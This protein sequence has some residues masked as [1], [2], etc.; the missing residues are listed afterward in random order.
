MPTSHNK[1]DRILDR[2]IYGT[3]GAILAIG[4]AMMALWLSRALW[5][6]A[7]VPGFFYMKFN[8]SLAF[9]G[10]GAGLLAAAHESKRYTLLAGGLVLLI[11]SLTLSE[12]VTGLNFGFDELLL[13]DFHYASSPYPGRMA[14]A[15]SLAFTLAGILL[16][17]PSGRVS[18]TWRTALTELVGFLVFALGAAALVGH[19]E[20]VEYA[21]S[22]GTYA[23]VAPQTAVGFTLLGIGLMALTWRQERIPIAS[24]PLWV[25]ASLCFAVLMIDTAA[26]LGFSTG[27]VYVPLVFCGLWFARPHA[28]FVFA[29]I[30]SLLAILAFLTKS[31]GTVEVHLWV[32]ATNRTIA[33]GAIWVVAVLVYLRQRS[34]MALE[35]STSR[36][37]AIFDHSVDGLIAINEHGIVED[38]NPA[39][40]RIF[41]YEASEVRGRNIKMLMPEP[42]HSEHDGYIARYLA[43]G[44]AKIIGTVGREVS[45]RRKDG[46]VFPMDL[47]ISAF[48][49][50]NE[51]HFS[52]TVRDIT[53]RKA[54]EAA[55]LR[56]TAA[57]E[58]S[59]R[60]L[61]DFAYIASHDLKE[62]LRGL[63]NNATFIKEDNSDNLNAESIR[64]LN[65]IAFLSQRLEL[66]VNDLL[67]FSRLGRHEMALQTT[68]LNAEIRDIASLME[69]TLTAQNATILMPHP[70]PEV[71]CNKTRVIEAFRNLIVNAIKYNDKAQKTVEIGCI[72]NLQTPHGV[73]RWAFYVRDN[74]IGIEADYH[75]E[76]FRIF[77]RLN[78]EDDSRRG[79]GVGLTFVQKIIHRH[80]GHIWLR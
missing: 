61:D 52:G 62:P 77:R 45:G 58:Q 40:E 43:T 63:H 37:K 80:G 10:A 30:A 18:G 19:L 42:Y 69:E 71:V 5:P 57:L 59:N 60:E 44:E 39:C 21:Y 32:E 75:D 36:Q 7:M 15:P 48:R 78:Q 6:E 79:T 50:R 11:G 68:D 12:Y 1:Q 4:A 47:S 29:A 3:A 56:Y 51:R 67:Y 2:T 20:N 9:I 55:L 35:Q 65:R 27:V 23:R 13:K 70:L 49:F 41:G 16:L 24:I 38:F 46:S 22:W 66:L 28:T 14:P 64:R 74:G 53:D 54:A 72:A 34:A 76:I 31:A 73:A 33:L 26:P 25:P 8:T 17:A